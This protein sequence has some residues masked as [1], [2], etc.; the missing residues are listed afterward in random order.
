MACRPIFKCMT[1]T[2]AM[3]DECWLVSAT[4]G[5]YRKTLM[6]GRT[7]RTIASFQTDCGISSR[8]GEP[9]LSRVSVEPKWFV[10]ISNG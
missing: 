8:F 10:E 7:D 1:E 5:G 9:K 6:V 3:P 2:A 4:L